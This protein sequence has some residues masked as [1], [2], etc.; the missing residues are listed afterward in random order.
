MGLLES[1]DASMNG[2]W[3]LPRRN[4]SKIAQL[5]NESSK[6]PLTLDHFMKEL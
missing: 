3:L 4:A 2:F 5:L 6:K 1:W